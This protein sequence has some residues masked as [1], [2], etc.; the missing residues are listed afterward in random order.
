MAIF[1]SYVK[2]PE[3]T[4]FTSPIRSWL[5][6]IWNLE[7]VVK[8][9]P[10]GVPLQIFPGKAI[11]WDRPVDQRSH[12]EC[13]II[14][15]GWA[16]INPVWK[17][18][19]IGFWLLL[20]HKFGN[21]HRDNSSKRRKFTVYGNVLILGNGCILFLPLCTPFWTNTTLISQLDTE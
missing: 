2:L 16:S 13:S 10:G 7:T 6:S 15:D 5:L 19:G 1:N 9:K 3:G 8:K 12:L 20:T 4:R 18:R 21:E 11:H 17:A 14:F